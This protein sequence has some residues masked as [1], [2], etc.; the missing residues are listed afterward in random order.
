[1]EDHMAKALEVNDNIRNGKRPP[2]A[3]PSADKVAEKLEGKALQV[4]ENSVKEHE[5]VRPKTSKRK[6]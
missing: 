6:D 5:P 3:T 4:N 2:R 1:M